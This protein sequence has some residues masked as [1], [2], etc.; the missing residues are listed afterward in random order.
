MTE[1]EFRQLAAK[2]LQP[3]PAGA[4]NLRR[5]RHPAVG[6]PQARQPALVLSARIGAGRRALRPL[7]VHR[8]AGRDALRSA[9]AARAANTAT[10]SWSQ[11]AEHERSA[12]SSCAPT[13]RASRWRRMPGLPRFCGG[14]VGYF[15]YDTVRYI[16]PQAGA[17]PTSRTRWARPTSCCCCPRSWRSSTTCRASCTSS[18]MP[19][20][21]SRAPMQK[22][23][24]RLQRAGCA[25][26]ASRCRSRRRRRPRPASRSR[27]FGEDAF[28]AAVERAKRYI[29]DGDIMQV[30]LSQRISQPL[31]RVAAVAVPRAARAQSVA[32]HV[33]FRHGRVPCRRRVAGDPG[34]AGGRHG[35]AAPDRRHA[36]ARRDARGGRRAR[37]TSCWPIRRSAPSTSC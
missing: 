18:S 33:L 4:R 34:A 24:A 32:V 29:F 22:A 11:Q 25:S 3:H 8:P 6:L 31:R 30:V 7:F 28:M 13:R 37:A 1:S 9:R 17:T 5:S 16:E 14:L 21:A 2:G 26:C 36:P 15:G 23:Q 19:I 10:T 12:A 35:D 20:R 27:E